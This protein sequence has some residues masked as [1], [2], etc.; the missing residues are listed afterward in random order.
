VRE[1][2]CT[3]VQVHKYRARL[4]GPLL[5]RIDLHVAV[6]APSYGELRGGP[7]AETSARVRARVVRARAAQTAR[8]GATGVHCN[9]RLAPAA[10]RRVCPL[11]R[12]ADDLLAAAMDRLGMS[13]RSVHRVV[14]VA[15]TLADLAG[16]DA[17]AVTDVAEALH[18]RSPDGPR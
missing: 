6:P 1:C 16:R 9:A 17:I 12:E 11:P 8:R 13:A 18:F 14:K 4:S 15:R 2:L 10:L 3:P 5:D 7:A